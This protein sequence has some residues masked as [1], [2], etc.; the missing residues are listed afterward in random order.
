MSTTTVDTP[1]GTLTL[2]TSPVGLRYV[3]FEGETPPPGAAPD[4]ATPEGTAV[5]A[6]A[7]AQ[8]AEYFEG[9]RT[10]F[11]LPLDIPGTAF[12]QKAW[13]ALATIPYGETIS[14][15]EQAG[16]IGYPR[17]TRA[18]GSANGRNPVPVVLPCHRVVASG[19]GLGGYGGGLDRKRHLLDL[20]QTPRVAAVGFEKP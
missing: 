18:V 19:G 5:A 17:A 6:A 16:R 8:L 2:I 11:D 9:S 15:S 14:Y 13:R 20:E 7:A 4:V 10:D 3:L 12:Q 1:I